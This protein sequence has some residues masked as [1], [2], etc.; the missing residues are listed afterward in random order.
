MDE[1]IDTCVQDS[2]WPDFVYRESGHVVKTDEIPFFHYSSF[3]F[4]LIVFCP[5]LPHSKIQPPT[6]H[7][8]APP[9]AQ[10]G[11][12]QDNIV[13]SP[14]PWMLQLVYWTACVEGCC[15]THSASRTL[16]HFAYDE[17]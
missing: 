6:Q 14:H 3:A 15:D 7:A 16:E 9:F 12:V 17:T 8:D 1:L 10:I 2:F 4:I 13:F 5:V 11:M